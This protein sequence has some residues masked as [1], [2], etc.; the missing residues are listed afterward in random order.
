[1]ESSI[2][3]EMIGIGLDEGAFDT[4]GAPLLVII[5]TMEVVDD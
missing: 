4:D 3:V 5:I 1:M 2:E